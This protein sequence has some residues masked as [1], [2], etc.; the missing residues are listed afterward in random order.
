M[1]QIALQQCTSSGRLSAYDPPGTYSAF[2]C[3]CAASTARCSAAVSSAWP[4]PTAPK[5]LALRRPADGAGAVV[6]GA[7]SAELLR[8]LMACF[9]LSLFLKRRGR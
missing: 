3:V 9:Q 8:Q 4:S 2:P 5:S 7:L 6:E 1:V